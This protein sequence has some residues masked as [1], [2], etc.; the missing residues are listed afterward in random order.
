M[1]IVGDGL[2]QSRQFWVSVVV[3]GYAR[4]AAGHL[5]KNTDETMVRSCYEK[6][7]I[8]RELTFADVVEL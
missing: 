5:V 3:A 6:H 8:T 2:G 7:K 4:T 1:A